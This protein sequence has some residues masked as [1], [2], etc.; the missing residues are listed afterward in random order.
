[1]RKC[2]QNIISHE[3]ENRCNEYDDCC[4]AVVAMRL[5][6]YLGQVDRNK[7][8]KIRICLF[9]EKSFIFM[10]TNSSTTGPYRA[11][12]I[13]EPAIGWVLIKSAGA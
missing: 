9:F 8:K 4:D 13:R 11:L 1:M 5:K 10:I 6:F 12:V 2:Y 3:W 7:K